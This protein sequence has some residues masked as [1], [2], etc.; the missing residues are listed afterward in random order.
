VSEGGRSKLGL[1]GVAAAALAVI[2][3]AAGPLLVAFVAS[4]AAGALVGFGVGLGLLVLAVTALCLRRR[5]S[6]G[7][8]A[9][10]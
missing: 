4:L 3:C 2:C 6:A 9:P 7:T 5:S 10:P 8:N 1:A